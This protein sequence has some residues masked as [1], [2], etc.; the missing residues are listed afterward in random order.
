[1]ETSCWASSG[2]LACSSRVDARPY[3]G[4]WRTGSQVESK[5]LQT[6][7]EDSPTCW[8]NQTQEP[9]CRDSYCKQSAENPGQIQYNPPPS[10]KKLL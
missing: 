7:P 4:A 5:W 6:M 9:V 2:F 10:K 8:E 3:K 1:M